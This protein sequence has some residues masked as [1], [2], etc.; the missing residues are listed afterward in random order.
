M[1]SVGVD[2]LKWWILIT[3]YF[4]KCR[5]TERK[6][7]KQFVL[8]WARTFTAIKVANSIHILCTVLINRTFKFVWFT[9]K[10]QGHGN[11]L[12]Q[13]HEEAYNA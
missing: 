2:I 13:Q 9:Q 1:G 8:N 4:I 5:N 12:K 7:V 10:W 11:I 6:T 3:V